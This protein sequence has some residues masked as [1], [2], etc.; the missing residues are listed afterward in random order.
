MLTCLKAKESWEM[1]LKEKLELSAEVKR[2]GNL[3]FKVSL[4]TFHILTFQKT[5]LDMIIVAS[6]R[7]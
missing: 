4:A 5:L 7:G 3:Y 6:F 1:D 2:K